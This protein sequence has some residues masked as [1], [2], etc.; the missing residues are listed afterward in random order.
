MSQDLGEEVGGKLLFFPNLH[1]V[2][3]R[4][5]F[6]REH[7]DITQSVFFIPSGPYF[8]AVVASDSFFATQ[9][10]EIRFLLGS[11]RHNCMFQHTRQCQIAL[12]TSD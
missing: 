1:S 2:L 9:L 4:G 8:S 3:G 7:Q 11:V 5:T 6:K 12:Y 10:L